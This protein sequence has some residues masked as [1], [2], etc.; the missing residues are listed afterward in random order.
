M[1]ILG[2]GNGSSLNSK[3]RYTA[4]YYSLVILYSDLRKY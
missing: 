1:L 3:S 4:L 2:A